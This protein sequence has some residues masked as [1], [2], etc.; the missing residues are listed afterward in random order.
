MNSRLTAVSVALGTAAVLAAAAPAPAHAD[1]VSLYAQIQGG[2]D[3]GKGVAG[4]RKD[5]AFHDGTTGLAYGAKVGV[6]ILLIDVW[7]AHTQYRAN[8]RLAGTWTELMAGFDVESGVGETK[9]GTRRDDGG[10]D[11]GYSAGY[12]RFGLGAGFGLGTGQQVDPPLDNAQITDKG[13][14]AQAEVGAGYRLSPSWSVGLDVP[15]NLGY[16][17]KSG[18]GAAAN[19]LGTN[20]L[21]LSASALLTLRLQ[22]QLK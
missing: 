21:E 9:G 7:A 6:E 12:V 5:D 22:I 1:V 13:F 11:G 18:N 10:V 14:L 17:F 4:D 19:D 8:G 15:V 2:G 16:M 3:A 20:Y